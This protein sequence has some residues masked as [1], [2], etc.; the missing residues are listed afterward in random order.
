[1][2]E[3]S[4][5]GG[6]EQLGGLAELIPTAPQPTGLPEDSRFG[7]GLFAFENDF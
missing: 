5:W 7:K 4:K 6:R 2:E 1:M 3:K